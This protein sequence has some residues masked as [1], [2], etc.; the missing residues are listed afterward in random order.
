LTAL[1]RYKLR[2]VLKYGLVTVL[3]ASA[4]ALYSGE[5]PGAWLGAWLLLGLWTG[6]LEEFLFGRRYRALAIP[7]Q[8]L[9]KVVLVNLLTLGL[10][11][12]VLWMGLE[13]HEQG[14]T[15]STGAPQQVRDLFATLGFY[16]VLLR[17]VLV[18]TIALLVVQ[19]EELLGRRMFV[20]LLLGRFDRPK[21]E[22]RIVLLMDLV[23]STALAE[24]M[25][26][27][28]YY[29]F[30][31]ATYSLLTDAVLR[32]EADIHKY[33][34]DEVILTWPLK[35]GARDANCL[36]LY[37]DAME[38]LHAH[39]EELRG[40]FGTVPRF[41][42]ALHGG[43]VIAAQV[44]HIKRSIELSGDVMNSASRMLGLA[45]EMDEGLLVSA[46][47]LARLPG[48]PD[49]FEVGPQ[50]IVPVKGRRREVRVHALRRLRGPAE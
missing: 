35:V 28:R 26:D 23:D 33:V 39:A 34:G 1:T 47:L 38:R 11:A 5:A 30:L 12:M 43:R 27:L 46:E 15:R 21:A 29:R 32:N 36:D 41:R 17:V 7:L 14:I 40:E 20:G 3:V 37:F 48:V 4:F 44:G 22:Q 42:A 10:L 16:Q 31:N 25:G 18:T 6:V 50:S 2:K 13:R 45:K 24:R 19:I 8:V 9:G 49:R